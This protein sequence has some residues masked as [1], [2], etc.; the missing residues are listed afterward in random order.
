M[1]KSKMKNQKASIKKPYRGDFR[2]SC[3]YSLISVEKSYGLK[4]AH[5]DS[6]VNS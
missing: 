1:H 6:L 3:G 5:F 2:L 4:Q